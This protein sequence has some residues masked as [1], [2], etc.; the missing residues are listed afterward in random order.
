[1]R[2][3]G[4]RDVAESAGEK[5]E[6]GIRAAAA[7]ASDVQQRRS[8]A[9]PGTRRAGRAKAMA[10][11]MTNRYRPLRREGDDG[12]ETDDGSRERCGRMQTVVAMMTETAEA[13]AVEEGRIR[14]RNRDSPVGDNEAAAAAAATEAAMEKA[15]HPGWEA[16]PQRL[17]PVGPPN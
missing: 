2:T 16:L 7:T 10:T 8:E 5:T 9:S 6:S 17:P 1:M 12:S 11:V 15:K 13:D 4:R 14:Q 3:H